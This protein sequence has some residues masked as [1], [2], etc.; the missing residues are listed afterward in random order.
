ML[1]PRTRIAKETKIWALLALL[2]AVA[3]ATAEAFF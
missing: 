2:V 1:D 3:A